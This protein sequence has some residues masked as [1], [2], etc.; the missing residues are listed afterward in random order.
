MWIREW[1]EEV[2]ESGRIDECIVDRRAMVGCG[3][4]NLGEMDWVRPV[5]FRGNNPANC[6]RLRERWGNV[7]VCGSGEK[8]EKMKK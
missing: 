7:R 2:R 1:E 3:E 5:L 6:G 4:K 8:L